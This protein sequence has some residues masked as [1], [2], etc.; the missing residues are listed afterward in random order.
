MPAWFL[1]RR[2]I[3]SA[4]D[5]WS[6]DLEAW[7]KSHASPFWGWGGSTEPDL[8]DRFRRTE[9]DAKSQ[10]GT[11]P[12]SVFH[13]LGPG[14]VGTGSLR[15][16]PILLRLH[17][18][19]FSIWPFDPP[20]WPR[21]IEIW[22][23]VLTGPVTK[24]VPAERAK[25][26]RD[27][28]PALTDEHFAQAAGSDDAFDAAVSALTMAAHVG[29]LATLPVVRDPQLLLEGIIWHPRGRPPHSGARLAMAP[30]SSLRSE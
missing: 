25:Y 16:M 22:P 2:K 10:A 28:Y 3:A 5:L 24:S 30:D 14:T 1:Q 19:G 4:H 6:R 18:A 7:L 26:L 21:V 29:K 9:K 23:R 8:P 17:N 15:G 12:Q 27:H 13:I 20:S 11:P